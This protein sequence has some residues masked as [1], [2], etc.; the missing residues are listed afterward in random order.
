MVVT[1]TAVGQWVP[2]FPPGTEDVPSD[3]INYPNNPDDPTNPADPG[4][5]NPA[6]PGTTD[7][8]TLPYVPGFTPQGPDGEPLEPVNPSNPG[9]GYWPPVI[10]DDP[11]Q[12]QDIT[13]TANEQTARI[14]FIDD[15]TGTTLAT[16]DID[17]VSDEKS[18]YTTAD[19]L[20]AYYA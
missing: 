4:P 12:S 1:Y 7:N 13:Y 16:D 15:T 18:T 5:D 19:R 10:P 3:P 17:G 8:P 2:H 20:A 6:D 11:K 14:V 9:E